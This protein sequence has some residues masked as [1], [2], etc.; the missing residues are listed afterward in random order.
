MSLE[1]EIKTE[2]TNRGAA[3]IHFVDVSQLSGQQN[4]ELNTSILFGLPLTSEFI[5]EVISKEDYV[6]ELI[7]NNRKNEDEFSRKEAETDEMADALADFLQS[8]G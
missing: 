2:L 1:A 3:F 4:K 6:Q 7:R 5:R 8:K